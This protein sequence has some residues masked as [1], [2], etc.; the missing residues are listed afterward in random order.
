MPVGYL[1]RKKKK[2]KIR[3]RDKIIVSEGSW[4]LVSLIPTKEKRPN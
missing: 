1:T 3:D 4:L 2:K